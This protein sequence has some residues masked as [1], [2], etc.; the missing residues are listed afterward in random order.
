MTATPIPRTLAL[1]LYGDLDVS[2]LD[3]LPPGR[4]PVRT[5]WRQ[6]QGR[7]RVYAFVRDQISAGRQAYVV[8]PLVEEGDAEAVAATTMAERLRRELGG[9]RVGLLHGRLSAAEKE[10]VMQQFAAR[11]LDLLVATTVIEVGIDVP[12]ATVMVIEG[13]DRF[14]LAQLHQ[15]RG[16]VG[17]GGEASYCV[18][19]ADPAGEE[20]ARRL[21]FFTFTTDGFAIAE[22]DLRLRGP[23][24]LLGSRQH[25]LPELALADLGR[26]LRLLEQA[27]D[28]AARLLDADPGLT[29][30]GNEALRRAVEVLFGTEPGWEG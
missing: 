19:I 3:G 12:N 8:C 14:G 27:R 26:D 9:V 15:L 29:K 5:Y 6:S 17:R 24:E 30:P 7:A 4:R 13:A 23:G 28:E 22:E 2:V 1:T 10:R 21:E 16:R 11:G 25:G 18:L 20:A